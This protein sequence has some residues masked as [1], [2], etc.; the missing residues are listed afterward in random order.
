MVTLLIYCLTAFQLR[1]SVVHIA[2]V[3]VNE[4]GHIRPLQGEPCQL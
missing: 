4:C 2:E 3:G 1:V